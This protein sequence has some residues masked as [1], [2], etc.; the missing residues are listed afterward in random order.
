M[1]TSTAT[2]T[3]F[4]LARLDEDE[5]EARVVEKE[6]GRWHRERAMNGPDG[7]QG[8][9]FVTAVLGAAC[10]PARVLAEV[11][12]KRR[13]VE[14]HA[15]TDDCCEERYGPLQLGDGPLEAGT[16]ALGNLT[17]RQAFATQEYIGCVTL[18]H[19]A[20]VYRDHPEFREEEWA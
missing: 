10:D 8:S 2:L 5:A 17:L 6:L 12:A 3:T 14:W 15:K 19:L 11:E 20:S 16:D 13:I 18:M 7:S 9:I 4:L 1:T